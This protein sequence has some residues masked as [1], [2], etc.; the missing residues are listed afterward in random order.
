M[1][2]DLAVRDI[3]DNMQQINLTA[4]HQGAQAAQADGEHVKDLQRKS[5]LLTKR[6]EALHKKYDD[7][8][9]TTNLNI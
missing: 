9:D 2:L 7:D 5:S 4:Q 1:P 8:I 6:L 3:T